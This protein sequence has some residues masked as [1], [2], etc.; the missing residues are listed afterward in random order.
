[1]DLHK[2]SWELAQCHIH[3]PMAGNALDIMGYILLNTVLMDHPEWVDPKHYVVV[4]D[5]RSDTPPLGLVFRPYHWTVEEVELDRSGL[6]Y[7]VARVEKQLKYLFDSYS[8]QLLAGTLKL[9]VSPAIATRVYHVNMMMIRA[10][11]ES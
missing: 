3:N 9:H 4:D 8:G 1:M 5:P 10:T 11:K 7:L 6:A 2:L